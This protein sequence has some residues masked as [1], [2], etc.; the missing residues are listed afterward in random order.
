MLT[1]ETIST[2]QDIKCALNDMPASK[3]FVEAQIKGNTQEEYEPMM[4][5]CP[6]DHTLK[7]WLALHIKWADILYKE[8][9]VEGAYYRTD[10]DV[11]PCCHACGEQHTGGH[12]WEPLDQ[13]QQ[14]TCYFCRKKLKAME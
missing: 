8:Q 12:F 2:P 5:D 3:A 11:I 13:D 9:P 6:A 10:S 4:A 7:T 14:E 1:L